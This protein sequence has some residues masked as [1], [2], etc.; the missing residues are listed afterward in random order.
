MMNP[1]DKFPVNPMDGQ[2]RSLKLPGGGGREAPPIYPIGYDRPVSDVGDPGAPLAGIGGPVDDEQEIDK[3]VNEYTS[4]GM[5]EDKARW[6]ATME[7]K[8]KEAEVK[9]AAFPVGNAPPDQPHPA[10]GGVQMGV[11][12]AGLAAAPWTMGISIPVAGAI[13]A[14]IEGLKKLF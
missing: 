8:N 7:M 2:L 14:G 6:A 13:N 3:L 10:W 9:Q 5:N 1:Q 11:S 12:G 4:T